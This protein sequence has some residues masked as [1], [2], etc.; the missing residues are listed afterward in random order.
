[1]AGRLFSE[2]EVNKFLVSQHA[3][4]RFG[5]TME[6]AEAVVWMCSERASFMTG[7]SITVDGGFL[8][9]PH[10]PAAA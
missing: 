5:T 10:P 7:Q 9:G 2:A 4:G 1:M 6:V 8:A 3:L